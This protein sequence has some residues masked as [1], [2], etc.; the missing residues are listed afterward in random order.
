[1]SSATL[2]RWGNGQGVRLN[3]DV[4]ED[5]GIK[6]G[7]QLDVQVREGR[8]VLTPKRAR[9]ITIPDFEAMFA[10]YRG[11]QP[12]EDGFANQIGRELL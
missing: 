11:P 4:V 7:D 8:I 5:A 3:R 10:G 12:Q 1:M 9:V 2:V 6:V